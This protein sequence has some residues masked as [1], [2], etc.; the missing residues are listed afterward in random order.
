MVGS[1]TSITTPGATSAAKEAAHQQHATTD[2]DSVDL[3]ISVNNENTM[4]SS[5]LNAIEKA[6]NIELQNAL[7]RQS[8]ELAE[9]RLRLADMQNKFVIAFVFCWVYR[10]IVILG[11][12]LGICQKLRF[13]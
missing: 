11:E 2:T 1:S 7:E 10:S 5:S 8:K 12:I 3:T 9:A 6:R 13:I 4:S